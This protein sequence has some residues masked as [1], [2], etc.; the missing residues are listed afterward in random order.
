[1]K[2]NLHLTVT[3]DTGKAVSSLRRVERAFNKATVAMRK[4]N[5]ELDNAHTITL[6]FCMEEGNKKWYKF[7]Q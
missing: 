3:V 6:T 1:M 4:L 7:W 5:E 2:H